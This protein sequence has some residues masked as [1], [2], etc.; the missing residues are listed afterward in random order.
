MRKKKCQQI[1]TRRRKKEKQKK[2]LNSNSIVE[3]T[4]TPE[5]RRKTL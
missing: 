1:L 2:G 5:I 3:E 4:K